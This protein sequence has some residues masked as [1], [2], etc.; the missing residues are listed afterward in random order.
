MEKR[1]RNIGHFIAED[2]YPDRHGHRIA[3]HFL[4]TFIV[5]FGREAAYDIKNPKNF[6]RYPLFAFRE[7]QLQSILI[8]AFRSISDFAI[9]EAPAYRNY[10]VKGKLDF[11]HG[12]NDIVC[13]Y[14]D[15]CF[16]IEIKHDYLASKTLIPNQRLAD[17][18]KSAKGQVSA[19][20]NDSLWYAKRSKRGVFRLSLL[21]SPIYRYSSQIEKLTIEDTVD[22][23]LLF[24]A[25]RKK[26]KPSPNYLALWKLHADLQ[27]PFSDG[28][29]KHSH[30]Y[31]GVLFSARLTKIK[32]N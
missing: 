26:L 10:M 19:S 1:I 13:S 23:E 6:F 32:A 27:G 20:Y 3:R 18:W 5:E 9:Y 31:Q 24:N 14:R 7:K 25:I 8:P 4:N 2:D 29:T 16:I 22:S 12:W 30:L 11:S 15:V 21:V 28:D 17:V